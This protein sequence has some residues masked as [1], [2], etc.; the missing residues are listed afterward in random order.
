LFRVET[1]AIN[2]LAALEISLRGQDDV[3]PVR[4]VSGFEQK[5]D[6]GF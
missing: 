3:F 1:G 5:L 6:T 2:D 4:Q